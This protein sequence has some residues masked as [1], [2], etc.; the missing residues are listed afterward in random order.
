M[1]A[2][3]M[4]IVAPYEGWVN[5]LVVLENLTKKCQA[6]NMQ[7]KK[8]K[9][10]EGACY[11]ERIVLSKD[12][13]KHPDIAAKLKAPGNRLWW[14]RN[15]HQAGTKYLVGQ[16]TNTQDC[17]SEKEVLVTL[18]NWP[19]AGN[20]E[21]NKKL[22]EGPVSQWIITDFKK[23]VGGVVEEMLTLEWRHTQGHMV[24]KLVCG[25]AQIAK[26]LCITIIDLPVT[27]QD[28][29]GSLN[30]KSKFHKVAKKDLTTFFSRLA[31]K[32]ANE[33]CS[34]QAQQDPQASLSSSSD[35]PPAV[36]Q[37]DFPAHGFAEGLGVGSVASKA[38]SDWSVL[39]MA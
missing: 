26:H 19:Y 33:E 24:W 37:E 34:N 20:K 2:P 11:V 28:G 32:D 17:L 9:V 5:S 3:G 6:H 35:A 12:V 7:Q 27:L 21:Y 1:V 36:T 25:H 18:G 15:E 23:N 13:M 10:T 39:D 22:L 8:G 30:F 16:T 29:V 31:I 4:A 38:S 14:D